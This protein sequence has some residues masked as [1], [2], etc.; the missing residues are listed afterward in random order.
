MTKLQTEILAD[1]EQRSLFGIAQ[2]ARDCWQNGLPYF[3]RHECP[4]SLRVKFA[5]GNLDLMLPSEP[6]S[7]MEDR[8]LVLGID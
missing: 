5:E 8:A 4:F 6:K 7:L 3:C 2:S 1:L